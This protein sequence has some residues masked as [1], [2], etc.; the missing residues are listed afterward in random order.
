D[1]GFA[2]SHSGGPAAN[3]LHRPPARGSRALERCLAQF[4]VQGASESI[5]CEARCSAAG[6]H[7]I[8]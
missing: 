8:L 3:A 5:A 6:E 1:P 4:R 2:R 7:G